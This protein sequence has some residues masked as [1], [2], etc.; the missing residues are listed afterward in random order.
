M[1]QTSQE[2]RHPTWLVDWLVVLSVVCGVE[3]VG[4]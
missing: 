2:V 4:R 3:G 1:E